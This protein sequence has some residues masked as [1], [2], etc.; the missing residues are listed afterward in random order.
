MKDA[1]AEMV[2]A[3]FPELKGRKLTMKDALIVSMLKRSIV[4][5]DNQ[6]TRELFNR[7][8]GLPTQVIDATVTNTNI[9]VD[10]QND[11]SDL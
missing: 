9:T 2:F 4:D 7:L 3:Q 5:G 10:I 1:D 6:A 8:E 11:E